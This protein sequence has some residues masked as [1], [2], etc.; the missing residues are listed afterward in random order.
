L[1]RGKLQNLDERESRSELDA[2]RFCLE[3]KK[4]F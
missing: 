3:S 2:R 4:I 1:I